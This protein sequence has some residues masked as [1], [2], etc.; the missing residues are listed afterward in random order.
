MPDPGHIF[1]SYSRNDGKAYAERLERDLQAAGY[2]TWR[3]T[4]NIDPYQDFTAEL[5]KLIE[6]AAQ[7]VV[8]VTPDVKRDNSF[9][10]REIGY[11]LL[12]EKPISV[13]MFA[14][15][16]SPINVVNHTRIDFHHLTW[17][18]ALLE[19]LTR[20]Q[21]PHIN[22]AARPDDPFREYLETL[23]KEIVRFL[24]TTVFTYIPLRSESAPDAV[25]MKE[26]PALL[27]SFFGTSLAVRDVAPQQDEKRQFDN[28][29]EAFEYYNGRVLLLG[30]PGAGKTTTLMAFARDAVARRL[31]DVNAPLPIVARIPDWDART[32]PSLADW[33]SKGQL[34]LKSIIDQGQGLL[35]LDGLDELGSE[36]KNPKTEKRYDP[37]LNF[38]NLILESNKILITCRDKDYKVLSDKIKLNGAVKLTDLSDEQIWT[39]LEEVPNLLLVVQNDD[40]LKELV[41]SPLIL[42]IFRYTYSLK[43]INRETSKLKRLIYSS[44]NLQ[45]QI[46]KS[47]IKR[48][49]GHERNKN[50]AK[51]IIRLN[52]IYRVLGQVAFNSVHFKSMS[53]DY[54]N[55][56]IDSLL[57]AE[58]LHLIQIKDWQI[59]F[60]HEI[61]RK[62]FAFYYSLSLLKTKNPSILIST[63]HVLA[64]LRDPRCARAIIDTLGNEEI[65]EH[66]IE[67]AVWALIQ[68]GGEEVVTEIVIALESSSVIPPEPLL[69]ILNQM[70][71][72]ETNSI[73]RQILSILSK[74]QDVPDIFDVL[75]R[76]LDNSFEVAETAI[77]IMG[78]LR[79]EF[80]VPDLINLLD[81]HSPPMYWSEQ[82]LCE[83]ILDALTEIATP[84][85]VAAVEEWKRK[86]KP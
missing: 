57:L 72:K 25:Q 12:C 23:Y 52:F 16:K 10:R 79:S 84:E 64:T 44:N 70:V 60:F 35:L 32:A 37:R 63:Y 14:N 31:E 53:S 34:R 77:E 81:L 51:K 9:V 62:Y 56:Y 68:I 74:F 59:T 65:Y 6:A 71:F 20:I 76:M 2:S 50:R 28:F 49:Y 18:T 46:V 42:S 13:L 47:Y 48:R 41:R 86:Q 82:R 39:Y 4:R 58:T 55:K 73:R 3:D 19:L 30:E 8:C 29:N 7:V 75:L 27:A 33:L 11:A 24:D 78:V 45:D 1:I 80:F 67:D 40:R 36:R 21:R 22:T 54:I 5:E 61:F 66:I 17:E 69:Y 15:I 85:A 43:E 38:I 83:T 26:V